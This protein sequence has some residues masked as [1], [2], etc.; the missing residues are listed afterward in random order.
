MSSAPRPQEYLPFPEHDRVHLFIGRPPKGVHMYK[1]TV[2]RE[3]TTESKMDGGREMVYELIGRA[4]TLRG[5]KMIAKKYEKRIGRA[6][7]ILLPPG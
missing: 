6:V 2:Q 1:V 7:D 3:R 4:L 5:A